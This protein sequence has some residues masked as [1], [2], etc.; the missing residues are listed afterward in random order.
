MP[1]RETQGEIV[2]VVIG[3]GNIRQSQLAMVVV[4]PIATASLTGAL[5]QSQVVSLFS[6]VIRGS[7][8]CLETLTYGGLEAYTYGQLQAGAACVTAYPI[9]A[10]T[11]QSQSV[12]LGV[13]KAIR[14]TTATQTQTISLAK[15]GVLARV[16]T[17][18]QSL[19]ILASKTLR[20]T[21]SAIQAQVLTLAKTISLFRRITQQ[22]NTPLVS[23]VILHSRLFKR[24]GRVTQ[25][26]TVQRG[27][28]F[29]T[30]TTTQSQSVSLVR[31][32]QV[33]RRISQSQTAR[34]VS[35]IT[36][37]LRTTQAQSLVLHVRNNSL[38]LAITQTTSAVLAQGTINLTQR[39]LQQSSAVLV[40]LAN[41]TRTAQQAAESLSLTIGGQ[42]L[43]HGDTATQST[44]VSLTKELYATGVAQQAQAIS[45]LLDTGVWATTAQQAQSCTLI[46]QP[47]PSTP[48]TPVRVF[49]TCHARRLNYAAAAR[50]TTFRARP[51]ETI[52]VARFA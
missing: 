36:R 40:Q 15:Q 24:T 45:L 37:V 6:E 8:A 35:S 47:I 18:S 32:N 41:L 5:T 4:A 38:T 16:V 52:F 33:S 48:I 27:G 10:T 19:Q 46:V 26:E 14:L 21:V 29:R 43:Q 39:V 34:L 20:R 12:S 23:R 11:I 31:Q 42:V 13:V 28:I 7:Y 9:T 3:A 17:Q 2:I 22:Q 30:V 49:S 25:S 51:R 1:V 44:N 50:P